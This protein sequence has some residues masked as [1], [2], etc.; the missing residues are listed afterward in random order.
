[1]TVDIR[2]IDGTGRR[3]RRSK[4]LPNDLVEKR[5]YRQVTEGAEQNAEI[6][7]TEITKHYTGNQKYRRDG[8]RRKKT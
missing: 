5:R 3:W 6:N 8:K 7:R 4:Q 2:Y 1:M